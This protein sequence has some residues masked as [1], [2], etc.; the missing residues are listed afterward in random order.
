MSPTV[1]IGPVKVLGARHANRARVLWA[2]GVLYIVHSANRVEKVATEEP[3]REATGTWRAQSD[4]GLI[5]FTRKGC[6]TCNYHLGKIPVE[7]IVAG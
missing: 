2:D 7:S 3:Y 1:D 5:S 4:A 6:P